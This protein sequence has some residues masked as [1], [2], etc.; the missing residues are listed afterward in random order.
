MPLSSAGA[1]PVGDRRGK[2]E[3]LGITTSV[4]QECHA[5]IPAKVMSDG[6]DVF[7]RKCCPEHGEVTNLIWRGVGEYLAAQRYVKPAWRPRR[8]CGDSSRP[9]PYGCGSCER[10]EQHLCLPMIEITSSC[11]L[12]CPICLVDAGGDRR[13][14]REEFRAVLDGL[15]LAEGQI[16]ILN[17]SGGEPLTHPQLLDFIDDALALSEVVRI[18]VSTNGLRLLQ[19][20]HLVEALKARDVVI[21]LQFDG[22]RDRIYEVLRGRPLL[23]EKLDILD[24]L[25]ESGMTTSLTMTAAGGVNDDQFGKMVELLLS[26][27]HIVS[28]MIQPLCFAGRA[29]GMKK[30]VRRLTM[31][32]IIRSLGAAGH[33]AVSA[34]DFVPLPCSHPLCFSLALYLMT[35]SGAV[36]VNRLV[37]ADRMLDL[38]ANQ[39]F[40]GLDPDEHARLKEA[41][42]DIWSAPAATVPDSEAAL[43]ALRRA[44]RELSSAD[45]SSS[46]LPFDPRKAFALG[47]RRVKSIF[48][49]AFQDE[50]TFDLARTRRCCNAYPQ[51]DGRLIPACVHNVLSRRAPVGI[52]GKGEDGM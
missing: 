17:L 9:C 45:L 1:E 18:S 50:E 35:D 30:Q 29:A 27:E 20:R 12:V 43:A 36:S 31:Q 52:L 34:E 39:L 26:R 11:D 2:R 46:R 6:R 40:F 8:F 14:S 28:M 19:D 48:I 3:T 37:R 38:M 10:H 41:V 32:D 25:G 21:S 42:Y 23:H 51:P 22:F 16:D 49:H 4:C 15:V 33:Q 44:L 24:L 13:M 5:L 7:F 47:E